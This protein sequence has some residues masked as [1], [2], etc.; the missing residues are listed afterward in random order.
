MTVNLR[1]VRINSFVWGFAY[2]CRNGENDEPYLPMEWQVWGWAE[3]HLAPPKELVV[4]V[5]Y[6]QRNCTSLLSVLDMMRKLAC[7]HP[8]V[9]PE[10]WQYAASLLTKYYKDDHGQR[11]IIGS[12]G[13]SRAGE[14]SN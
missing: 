3:L 11:R 9:T 13:P 1:R 8:C 6:A 12:D 2:A 5:E 4:F 7:V 10:D 14:Y